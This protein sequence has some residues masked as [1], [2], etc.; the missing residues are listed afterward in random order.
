MCQIAQWDIHARSV[1]LDLKS[2][3]VQSSPFCPSLPS[4]H[5]RSSLPPLPFSFR[6]PHAFPT[7][8]HLTSFPSLCLGVRGAAAKIF[9]T[10][11]MLVGEFHSV[12]ITQSCTRKLMYSLN[13]TLLLLGTQK[14][15]GSK[16][17]RTP[18]SKST[19]VRTP[20]TT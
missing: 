6:I 1:T 20:G 8:S 19:G 7:P 4:T 15:V 12:L 18:C 14:V 17:T 16:D 11:Q 5:P 3:G 13:N 2:G 10:C 9:L